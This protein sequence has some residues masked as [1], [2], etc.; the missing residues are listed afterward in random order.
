[1]HHASML[2]TAAKLSRYRYM[3]QT[4]W[5]SRG[6]QPH[7]HPPLSQSHSL[8][9]TANIEARQD[10]ETLLQQGRSRY[11]LL[12]EPIPLRNPGCTLDVSLFQ[13]TTPW[14]VYIC[15]YYC[16]FVAERGAESRV[17]GRFCRPLR[18]DTMRVARISVHCC[19]PVV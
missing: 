6:S 3:Y 15:Q 8:T 1:M 18:P 5:V 11:V 4:F 7:M 16:I 19:R 9:P 13:D 12:P 14:H 17:S 10:F 2:A